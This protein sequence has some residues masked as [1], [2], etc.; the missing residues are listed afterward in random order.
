MGGGERRK[1]GEDRKRKEGKVAA[2]LRLSAECSPGVGY[3]QGQKI[4]LWER[5]RSEDVPM[6]K[7]T[8][9]GVLRSKCLRLGLRAE[10]EGIR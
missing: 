3:G 7:V 5:A 4:E 1:E 9:A 6:E 8:A 2:G 10:Q